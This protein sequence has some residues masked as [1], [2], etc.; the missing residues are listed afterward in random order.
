MN[1]VKFTKRVDCLVVSLAE[2]EANKESERMHANLIVAA[3]EMFEALKAALAA[4]ELNHHRL[5]DADS[6]MIPIIAQ[7]ECLRAIAIAKGA[8]K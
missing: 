7:N 2:R 3:P 6:L 1:S 5:P 4:L 8:L